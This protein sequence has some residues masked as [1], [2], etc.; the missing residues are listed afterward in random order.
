MGFLWSRRAFATVSGAV[1]RRFESCQA[2]FLNSLEST[3]FSGFSPWVRRELAR[4]PDLEVRKTYVPQ[5]GL[6]IR[7]SSGLP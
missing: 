1:C 6:G 3:T 5:A 2:R 7:P 4:E